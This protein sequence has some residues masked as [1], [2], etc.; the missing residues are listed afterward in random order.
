M[1]TQTCTRAPSDTYALSHNT[2]THSHTSTVY[3]PKRAYQAA[4]GCF[5]W[6]KGCAEASWGGWWCHQCRRGQT[7]AVDRE[8]VHCPSSHMLHCLYDI[9]THKHTHT[10]VF[11]NYSSQEIQCR[12]HVQHAVLI[13]GS[14]FIHKCRYLVL[15]YVD[16]YIHVS[17]TAHV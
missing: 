3:I 11:L 9:S 5:H 12:I 13:I 1:W 4:R 15:I 2:Q 17:S 6:L 16:V 10:D 8:H 7:S 14:L